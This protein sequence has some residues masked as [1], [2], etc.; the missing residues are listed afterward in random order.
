V[1]AGAERSLEML[2]PRY[3]ARGVRLDVAYLHARPGIHRQLE[4]AGARVLSLAG[5]GGRAGWIARATSLTRS[6]GPDLVHTTLFEAD[7]AG[8]VAARLARVPVVSSLVNEEYDRSHLGDPRLHRWK[9]RGGQLVDAA[10]ARLATRLHAVSEH[11][12][13]T[14]ARRLQFPRERIDV[15]PRGRDP[16]LLGG[17]TP[18]RREQARRALGFDDASPML[19]AVARHE[20]QKGLDVLVDALVL[21]R[22]DV[23]DARLVV[24]GRYG[25]ETQLLRERVSHLGLD[26]AV[27][28]LG[29]RDDVADLLCAAD[30]FVLPSR[31]EGFPG[32]VVEAM[33]LG[34]PVVATDLPQVREAVDPSCALLVAAGSSDELAGGVR[35]ALA[36]PDTAAARATRAL[37]R[38]QER[39]TIDRVADEML[40]F[41]ARALRAPTS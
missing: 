38:F 14:M 13:S 2:A 1:P 27:L 32:S 30:L 28:L 15:V 5:R 20:H 26:D 10:T 6:V 23:P 39:F 9:I 3:A 18:E 33:A 36:D 37:R 35:G 16:E 41:Y 19:L 31:R 12:A 29:S 40:A 24:A 17:R 11:V 7:V 4:T 21:V 22:R 25:N 34:A 8:R